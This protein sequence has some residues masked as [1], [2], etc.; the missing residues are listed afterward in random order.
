MP[1][2]KSIAL[3]VAGLLVMGAL[4]GCDLFSD[5]PITCVDAINCLSGQVCKE[6]FCVAATEPPDAGDSPDASI[7]EDAGA[8]D[9][10]SVADAGSPESGTPMM[11]AGPQSDGGPLP[12]DSGA[13][14][15]DA[16]AP[17]L[18]AGD[19][20]DA[21]VSTADAAAGVDSGLADGG[22]FPPDAGNASDSGPTADGGAPADAGSAFDAGP[23]DAG[24]PPVTIN[25]EVGGFASGTP[26]VMKLYAGT[27]AAMG[28]E[29]STLSGNGDGAFSFPEAI[30]QDSPFCFTIDAQP[31]APRQDCT[32]VG[33]VTSANYT[34]NGSQPDPISVGCIT[35]T[36]PLIIDHLGP[37]GSPDRD[38]TLYEWTSGTTITVMNV[39]AIGSGTNTPVN[40]PEGAFYSVDVTAPLRTG[41][42]HCWTIGGW[43]RVGEMPVHVQL[44]CG[45]EITVNLT[46]DDFTDPNLICSR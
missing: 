28:G 7:S 46:G 26:L 33:A 19:G 36:Q 15:S 12:P 42:E 32:L 4:S 22:A 37:S 8:A 34:A 20:L 45:E 24:P 31:S 17:S 13:S 38:V 41:G 43:G 3:A 21:A 30:P 29:L 14:A 27:C 2:S 25:A 9:A 40:L 11:D 18:D 35:K 5:E 44:Y 1:H 23:P 16:G 6:G 39:G 10:G